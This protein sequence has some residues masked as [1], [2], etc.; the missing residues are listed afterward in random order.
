[1]NA[2]FHDSVPAALEAHGKSVKKD[3]INEPVKEPE[4]VEEIAPPT[5]EEIRTKAK[6]L[7]IKFDGRTSDKTLLKK[8][9]EA[10]N[11]RMD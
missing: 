2:G 3:L 4:K 1:M 10:L 8:I 11:G 7:G 5:S 6:E 9:E